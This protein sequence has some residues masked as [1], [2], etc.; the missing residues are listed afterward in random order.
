MSRSTI[1][2]LALVSLA[3]GTVSS[4][5]MLIPNW[6]GEAASTAAA[7]I[8]RLLDVTVVLSCYVFSIVMVALIYAV[9]RWR[10]KPGDESD[11]EPIH[12]NTRL[13]VLWTLI[14]TLIVLFLAG[15]SWVVLDKIEAK[16]RNPMVVDVYSQQFAWTFR[17]PEQGIVSN[18]LHV[19]L[20]RQVELR[21][22]A[23]DVLHSFWVP[24]WRLKKDNVP[25][26]DTSIVVTPDRLGNFQLLCT[27]MCGAGHGVMRA[28]VVVERMP[29]LE[30][31]ARTQDKL[32]PGEP[33]GEYQKKDF[34]GA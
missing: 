20:G 25:G 2:R 18:E 12:G 5:L 19:P 8:D 24:E 10:V 30:R 4:F 16:E 15:Y 29:A 9:W 32:P 14:P 6:N 11:G 3:L 13:E 7:D 33:Q 27:E 17:Y 28:P 23:L 1:L 34:N 22:H 26:I 21:M 31:W